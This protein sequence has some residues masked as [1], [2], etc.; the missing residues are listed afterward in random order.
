MSTWR[1]FKDNPRLI[2]IYETRCQIIRLIREWFWARDFIE[3]QTPLALRFPGQEPYLNP[4]PV[5]FVEPSGQTS[6]FYLHTSPEY[7]LKKLL[8]A[9]FSKIFEI[10]K[11]FRNNEDFRGLHSPE[12]TIMEWYRAPGRYQD[13]MDDLEN[14][15]KFIGQKLGIE[16]V[17]Y[18]GRS[19]GIM[20]AWERATM[21]AVWQKYLGVNLDD[22]L[23][24]ADIKKYAENLGFAVAA[25]DAYEDIFFKIFLNKIEPQLGQERPIF[26]YDYPAILTSLSRPCPADPRY[27]ERAELYIAGLELCNGFGE[28]T[29][30]IAQKQQLERDRAL[31]EKL[32]KPTWPVDPDFIAA[33]ESGIPADSVKAGLPA[34]T[35]RSEGAAGVALGLDRVVLLFTG[36]KDINEVIFNSAYD[37]LQN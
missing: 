1:E 6:A 13:F 24:R 15:F 3:T 19:V 4:I 20:P 2:K 9:G 30:P 12:F 18:R 16:T 27:A 23:A 5:K 25:E 32:G 17:S 31:R 36:A 11:T 14:L 8:A 28:L 33:L 34:S 22:L 26:I 10:T 7:S 37:Q 21:R 35:S 29:D